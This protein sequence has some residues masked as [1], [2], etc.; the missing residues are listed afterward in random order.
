MHQIWYSTKSTYAARHC[1]DESRLTAGISVLLMV[2]IVFVWCEWGICS[3]STLCC[4]RHYSALIIT[5]IPAADVCEDDRARES[6]ILSVTQT[7]P[8]HHMKRKRQHVLRVCRLISLVGSSQH[9]NT[10]TQRV[11]QTAALNTASWAP[12]SNTSLPRVKRVC[13]DA[14]TFTSTWPWIQ[15]LCDCISTH[16]SFTLVCCLHYFNSTS[17]LFI[18]CTMSVTICTLKCFGWGSGILH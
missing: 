3:H 18:I 4:V 16:F 6:V 2:L 12:S 14:F 8:D 7:H 17:S 15:M 13:L 9:C 1:E 10:E 5:A 11:S